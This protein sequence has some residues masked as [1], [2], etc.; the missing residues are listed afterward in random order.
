MASTLRAPGS[1]VCAALLL[2]AAC[3]ALTVPTRGSRTVAPGL[4]LTRAGWASVPLAARGPVSAALGSELPAYRVLSAGRGAWR[5]VSG[6]EALRVAFGSKGAR[7]SSDGFAVGLRLV[8]IG[9]GNSLAGVTAVMPSARGNR[10]T[11]THRGVTEWYANGPLGIEQGFTIPRPLRRS[12]AGPLALS[13]A[14]SGGLRPVLSAGGR[15]L[16]LER[17]G[18]VLLTY[19]GLRASDASGRALGARLALS[20]GRLSILVAA[21][22]ARYPV[23]IDPLVQQAELTPTDGV[24]GDS[25]GAA[26]AVS[27]DGS[28]IAVGA[29]GTPSDSSDPGAVYLFTKPA[30]GWAS[31]T[32]P[33]KMTASGGEAGDN[34]GFSVA[35][36]GDGST[37]VAGARHVSLNTGAVYVF[38]RSGAAWSTGTD[39]AELTNS[40]GS[41]GDSLGYSVAVSS[42]GSTV[43]A[44]A[45]FANS[46]GSGYVFERGGAGWLSEST[47]A[48]TLTEGSPINDPDLAADLGWSAAISGDGSTIV[49]G[50]SGQTVNGDLGGQGGAYVYV[51][52][53]GSWTS[54]T[55]TAKLTASDGGVHDM[56]G[57]SVA[58]SS[59]GSTIV[60]GAP[61]TAN[62][63]AVYVFA[64]PA[65]GGWVT[66]TQTAKLTAAGA[67][68][69]NGLGNSVAISSDGSTVVSG[70]YTGGA[71]GTAYLFDKPA[72]GWTSGFETQGLSASDGA[73]NDQFGYSVSASS[74][75]STVVAGATNVQS[76]VGAAYPFTTS[77]SGAGPFALTVGV[78]PGGA[79]SVTSQPAGIACPSSCSATFAAGTSVTLTAVPAAGQ[80]FGG[81]SGDCAGARTTECT[82]TMDQARNVT[83]S[84]SARAATTL[85]LSCNYSEASLAEFCTATVAGG[86][87]PPSGQ[88]VFQS[89]SGAGFPAGNGCTLNASA[90]CQVVTLAPAVTLGVLSNV[91]VSATYNG[92]ATH[93]PSSATAMFS[94]SGQLAAYENLAKS[95]CGQFILPAIPG[96]SLTGTFFVAVPSQVTGQFVVGPV[97]GSALLTAAQDASLHAG[98]TENAGAAAAEDAVTSSCDGSVGSTPPAVGSA[99]ALGGSAAAG[100]AK[101]TPMEPHSHKRPTCTAPFVI[102]KQT[103]MF[104]APGRYVVHIPLTSEG[105]RLFK[106]LALVDKRY[107]TKQAALDKAYLK[108][109]HRKRRDTGKAP[110]LPMMITITFKPLA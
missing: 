76:G 104:N 74:D 97:P 33:A 63:G 98:T 55:E 30:G 108:K 62:P 50:A 73:A 51:G 91:N 88:V 75:G 58:T 93:A 78:E 39:A 37:V 3:L 10:V 85:A 21:R 27:G 64:E 42:D 82:V 9:Y 110:R 20:G 86:A 1:R 14:L 5:A 95:A 4:G 66:D 43:V 101:C 48:A 6:D 26:V 18:R 106:A 83:A 71:R 90:S 84:F 22:H 107:A 87:A 52:S 79:G 32:A 60:A 56:L 94:T 92:D 41:P 46:F 28:T 8:G 77:G 89:A 81:W 7:V 96:N 13:I 57:T 2:L 68:A 67:A 109:H 38:V 54:G 25:F 19:R 59:D 45:P 72:T 80:T 23:R 53:E 31:V 65:K 15:Q 44:G 12:A 47:P 99:A 69:P 24:S 61:S 100:K 17:D 34:L 70:A 103:F 11:F 36:S 35:I 16:N 102:A 105:K 49:L 40:G 29:P